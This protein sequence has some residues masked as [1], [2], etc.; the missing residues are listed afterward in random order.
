M[1]V[2]TTKLNKTREKVIPS[3]ANFRIQEKHPICSEREETLTWLNKL[4][5]F[6]KTENLS[7]SGNWF[8]QLILLYTPAWYIV[9][10][11]VTYFPS[12]ISSILENFYL[13]SI[14]LLGDH[15]CKFNWE[16]F[17]KILNKS[18]HCSW[19]AKKVL[20]WRTSKT[21]ILSFWGYISFMKNKAEA[22]SG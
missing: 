11:A 22:V 10:F 4:A 3:R 6:S 12:E 19:A 18:V 8:E 7:I 17:T 1:A 16:N 13:F 15:L 14:S 5:W 21:L 20:I 9:L 2:T